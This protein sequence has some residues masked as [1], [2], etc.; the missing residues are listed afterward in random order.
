MGS[1][2]D[3]SVIFPSNGSVTRCP[4]SS[5]GSLGTVPPLRRYYEALRLPGAPAPL[6]RSARQFHLSVEASGSPRFLGNPCVHAL[7][8]DSGFALFLCNPHPRHRGRSRRG[9]E[10][11]GGSCSG[12]Y[13]PEPA[14]ARVPGV[15][16]PGSRG[17][18]R[19]SHKKGAKPES[20]FVPSSATTIS[21][22]T[23]TTKST[24]LDQRR[25]TSKPVLLNHRSTCLIPCLACFCAT[26]AYAAPMA[27][28]AKT[29][30][31]RTPTT[32]FASDSRRFLCKEVPNVPAIQAGGAVA[33]GREDALGSHG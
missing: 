22:R 4:L 17:V 21:S 2:P 11:A 29:A 31:C 3:V 20:K 26:A 23:P 12:P 15:S 19:H 24:K 6:V 30:A 33:R 8:S 10:G 1:K 25:A 32:L 16:Q 13:L 18:H 9:V 5:T 7:A 27:W 14:P 28:I